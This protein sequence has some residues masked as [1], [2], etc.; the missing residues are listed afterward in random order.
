MEWLINLFVEQSA[1]QAV[2][3]LS[4]ITAIGL[5]LGKFM[6]A[7]FLSELHLFSLL[8]FWP[9]ISVFH[10]PT[11]AELR[12]KFRTGTFCVCTRAAG[13]SRLLQFFPAGR[14][15][16]EHAGAGSYFSRYNNGRNTE[17]D[18]PHRTT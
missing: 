13:G 14:I 17:S 11:D 16:S 6:F 18:H 9:D 3:I 15:P 7:E 4:L 5:G 12:R 1:L 2:V 10:R 8:A